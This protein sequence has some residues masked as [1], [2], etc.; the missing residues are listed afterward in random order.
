VSVLGIIRQVLRTYRREWRIL[1][2]ASFIVFALINAVE[3]AVP[4]PDGDHISTSRVIVATGLAVGS[5][6][7]TSFEEAFY[8]GVVASAVNEVRTGNPRP[9][10]RVVAS[11]VPY[12]V[13][14]GLN[15]VIALATGGGLLL[16]I[17]PGVVAST[18]ISLSPALAKI[19]HLGVRAALARSVQLARGHFWKL[20]VIVWGFYLFSEAATDAIDRALHGIGVEYVA[21]T[22]ADALIAPFY[23]LALVLC[24]Y[25]LIEP[26]PSGAPDRR[27]AAGAR[28]S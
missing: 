6:A 21:K 16:L 15:L 24:V 2:G 7:F 3:L 9:S 27:R 18:Y 11:S 26:R 4:H 20:L 1:L 22:V 10:L 25:A 5:L 17:V 13:L 28:G 23:G 12:L 14:I 8:E 19:E